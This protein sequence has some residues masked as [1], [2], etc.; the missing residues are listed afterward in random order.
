MLGTHVSAPVRCSLTTRWHKCQ[1]M[2]AITPIQ[3]DPKAKPAKE[4][5][6]TGKVRTAIEAMVWLGLKRDEAAQH[7][8]MKDNS[9]YVAMRRPDVKAFYLAECEMLRLSGKAR[10]IHR[11]DEISEQNDNKAAAVNAIMALERLGDDNPLSSLS[12]PRTPGV[13]VQII[14]NPG[15][16]PIASVSGTLLTQSD[17][18]VIETDGGS[19]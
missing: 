5:K 13:V 6:I 9:L 17:S 18:P 15:T 4:L 1:S 12:N 3:A 2:N 8:G 16:Q 19:T 10:R 7:A 11:L 14:N